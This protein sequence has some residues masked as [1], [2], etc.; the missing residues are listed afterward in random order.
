M[1]F[2]CEFLLSVVPHISCSRIVCRGEI[3]VF[4][5]FMHATD[6]YNN[7]I[8]CIALQPAKNAARDDNEFRN[9]RVKYY[10]CER[11]FAAALQRIA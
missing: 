10:V 11:Y 3:G 2:N 6:T 4:Q 5:C 8:Y 9:D 1:R 7:N